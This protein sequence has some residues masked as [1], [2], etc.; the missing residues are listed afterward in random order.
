MSPRIPP[1]RLAAYGVLGLPLAMAALP[2]YIQV[3][4]LYGE[5]L[6]LPLAAVGALLLASRA[7]DALQDPLLGWWSDR[8]RAKV[9]DRW[10]FVIGAA[11][12]LAA[13]LV[14]LFDPPALQ[15]GALLAWLA[16]SLVVVHFAYSAMTV[17]YQAHGS[18]M[19]RDPAERT[20]IVAW[21]EGFALGGVF[22]AATV[23]ELLRDAQGIQRGLALFAMA[24]VPVILLG[25][26]VAWRG[27]PAA[28]AAQAASAPVR[29]ALLVPLH[30]AAFRRLLLAFVVNGIAAAIPA[31]LVLFYVDDVIRA[32]TMAAAF[33]VA[34]FAAGALGLPAWTAVSR[35]YGKVRAWA[36]GMGLAIATF[37]FAATL[38][39]GDTAAFFAVCVASGL[40]LGADLALPPS[41]LAD[42]IDTDEA[43]GRGRQ[44]GA[45]FGLWNLATKLNLALAAGLALPALSALGYRPGAHDA[46][47]V[48]ALAAIYAL[49][50][51][52]L[53][54]LAMALV[55]RIPTPEGRRP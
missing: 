4:K 39:A 13:G 53:K 12:M 22:L 35:R 36:C 26:I 20:R 44:E 37:A 8:R 16:A 50:P 51:C 34:Y 49:L 18:E 43:R 2:L 21:R 52:A 6:G 25:A 3:P 48:A 5:A 29:D 32:P 31:T 11:P 28:V 42:V 41:L 33:L 38:R 47:S 19:A 10:A 45:Y 1:A 15:G 40:A 27:A 30:N 23:P 24:S 55:L 54:A 17:S 46:A 9:G 14:A 7:L